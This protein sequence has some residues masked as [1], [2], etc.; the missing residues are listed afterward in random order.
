MIM[1]DFLYPIG[2]KILIKNEHFTILD[3]YIKENQ[4][5]YVLIN[6]YDYVTSM[7]ENDLIKDIFMNNAKVSCGGNLSDVPLI[8]I[9]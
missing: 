1:T 8:D 5:H 6:R 4:K 7:L 3:Q 9:D 2:A